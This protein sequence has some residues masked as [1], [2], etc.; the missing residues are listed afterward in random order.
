MSDQA[1]T[2]ATETSQGTATAVTATPTETTPAT[3]TTPSGATSTTLTGETADA[4]VA[5]PKEGE[6]AE[7]AA[8]ETPTADITKL[9]FPEGFDKPN[10]ALLG[11]FGEIAKSL[12]LS[13]EGAQQLTDLYTD[14]IKAASEANSQ[15]WKVT[16]DAWE[17]EIKNDPEIGGDKLKAIQTNFHKVLADPRFN[18][19]GVVEALMLTGAGSNPAINRFMAKIVN[20]LT[21]GVAVEGSPGSQR[22]APRSA[23]QA[24]YPNLPSS[25]TGA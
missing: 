20:A 8:T 1:G 18:T 9:T 13:Q 14:T 24:L 6:A 4:S 7:E 12:S 2:L 19:P 23:A 25:D 16:I 22:N 15:A 17:N 11:R 10:E 21:E 5:A 3:P